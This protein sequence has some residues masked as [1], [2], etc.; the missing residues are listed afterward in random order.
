MPRI[1]FQG[2]IMGWNVK[3]FVVLWKIIESFIK[4]KAA[5]FRCHLPVASWALI[6]AAWSPTSF[7][8]F[9]LLRIINLSMMK[10]EY[11][12]SR[13]I[14][15]STAVTSSTLKCC[16]NWIYWQFAMLKMLFSCYLFSISPGSNKKEEHLQDPLEAGCST[17]SVWTKVVWPFY[18]G[19]NIDVLPRLSV[20]L[21]YNVT[22][23][24]LSR[25]KGKGA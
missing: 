21:L 3:V 13:Q 14:I 7:P 17:I 9:S 10:N 2:L 11:S 12:A 20:S 16:V 5:A 25:G 22:E 8:C 19:W 6:C 4:S 15:L 18:S 1:H 23:K 24:G